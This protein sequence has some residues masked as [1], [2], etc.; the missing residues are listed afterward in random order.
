MPRKHDRNPVPPRAAPRLLGIVL[1]DSQNATSDCEYCPLVWV[2]N[3]Q[4][5]SEIKNR[6]TRF[7]WAGPFVG[8]ATPQL[9]TRRVAFATELG[10]LHC[11]I[12]A[13][14]VHGPLRTLAVHGQPSAYYSIGISV[15]LEIHHVRATKASI[16]TPQV[17]NFISRE[18]LAR[19]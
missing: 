8:F 18:E 3:E 19:I 11:R 9:L 16:Q 17:H 2:E 15:P 12:H 4:V 10:I 5:R 7:H 13:D 6:P 1:G 14:L